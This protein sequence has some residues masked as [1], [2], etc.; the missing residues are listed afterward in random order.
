MFF[1]WLLDYAPIY[2]IQHVGW[3]PSVPISSV[4]GIKGHACFPPVFLFYF[5][6]KLQEFCF[7]HM[8]PIFL[9]GGKLV[10]ADR[11]GSGVPAVQRDLC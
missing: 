6:N 5:R 9:G 10:R 11:R 2:A 7:F 4:I 3:H 8:C 1:L